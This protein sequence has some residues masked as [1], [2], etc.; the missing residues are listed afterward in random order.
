MR[1][2]SL[3]IF[4]LV[5]SL[6]AQSAVAQTKADK[7]RASFISNTKLLEKKPL[8]PNA[9]GARSWGFKWV[10]DTDQVSVG[11]CGS[12]MQLIPEKKNKFK[13][14]LL[15]QM[16]FGMAVFKLENPERKDDENAANLAG[17]ESMLR[18]YEVMVIEND[19]AKN[20]ELDSLVVKQKNGELKA[21]IDAAFASGKCGVKGTK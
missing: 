6:A 15:M 20:A 3:L 21:V 18:A 2:I 7:D 8:D 9:E 4:V 19:K 16:T 12:I 11:L 13:G 1:N 5:L 14:E 10:A 17:I